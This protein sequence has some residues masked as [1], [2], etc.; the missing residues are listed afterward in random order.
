MIKKLAAKT[1]G[2]YTR[3]DVELIVLGKCRELKRIEKEKH[4]KTLKKLAERMERLLATHTLTNYHFFGVFPLLT[5]QDN[6]FWVVAKIPRAV[7]STFYNPC[8]K[9]GEIAAIDPTCLSVTKERVGVL[10]F[11]VKGSDVYIVDIQI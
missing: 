4:R 5:K 8:F 3:E 11:D 10:F 2:L 6:F 1:M 7:P 9:S